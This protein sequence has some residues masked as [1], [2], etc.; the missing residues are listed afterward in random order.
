MDEV[1][2]QALGRELR[3]VRRL[4]GLSLKAVGEP[5]GVSATYLQKIERGQVEWPSPQVL[6]G[7]ARVLELDYG[8]LL[9]RV[10]YR[11][12]DPAQGPP[13]RAA[14]SRPRAPVALAS[15]KGSLIRRVFQS[16]EV[17]DE[18]LERLAQYLLFLR[19][20]RAAESDS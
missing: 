2:A 15:A 10:G 6:E 18:E 20:Q 8:E 13:A 7:L 11:I 19:Q 5:A 16:D 14:R 9:A 4:R 3:E 12:P 1:T 17:T